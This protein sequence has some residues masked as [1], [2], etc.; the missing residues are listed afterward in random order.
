MDPRID[1]INRHDG[2]NK[3]NGIT[4]LKWEDG[5]GEVHLNIADKHTNP[6]GLIHGGAMMGMLDVV[7]ALTGSYEEPPHKLMPGLTLSL[8]TEFISAARTDDK[9][10]I[11]KAHKTGGGR[12]IFFA[13]GEIRTP[14]NRLIAR[15]SGVF[16]RGRQPEK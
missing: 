6:A 10:L 1:E 14:D 16:K 7:L 5:R 2:F 4:I 13:E 3:L 9:V 8:N 12:N 15:A 11:G